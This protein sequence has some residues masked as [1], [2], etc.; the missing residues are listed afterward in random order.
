MNQTT[1]TVAQL[2][3]GRALLFGQG[4]PEAIET[5]IDS[6]SSGLSLVDAEVIRGSSIAAMQGL[7]PLQPLLD[8]PAIEEIWV[9]R[10]HEIWFADAQGNHRIKAELTSADIQNFVARML[11]ASSRRLD[12]SN[13]FVDATLADGSRL[14]VV[15]PNITREHWSIN[16]R[17]FRV[18]GAGLVDLQRLGTLVTSQV[19]KLRDLVARGRSI[20]ISGATQSGKTTLLTA[21]LNELGDCERLVTVEDTFEISCKVDDW[22][23]L[24]TREAVADSE[25]QVDLRRL[26][27]ETLRMRPTRIAVG[28]V[29][30]AEAL[31]MLLAFNSGIPG[32]CTIHANSATHA[33]QKLESLP[34]LAGSGVS[35]ELVQKLVQSNVGAVAHCVRVGE[36]R[37]LQEIL[38]V[39]DV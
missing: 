20:V 18:A 8:D 13:P 36:K 23:A 33:L 5:G 14:H 12:R 38:E 39:A 31:E 34:L 30:G 9:N 1:K 3:R 6:V 25:S 10:P 32:L 4:V 28:E 24:Q 15:I 26:V 17:K 22:V 2:A 27:R 37:Q 21:L 16:I 29:R 19:Q 11:R 7:G 35:S